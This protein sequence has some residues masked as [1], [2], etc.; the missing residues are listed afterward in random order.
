MRVYV[1]ENAFIDLLLSSTEVYKKECLGILLGYSLTDK[2]VIEHAFSYQTASRQHRAVV[3]NDKSHKRL[4]PVLR[5]LDRIEIIGDFHSHTQFGGTK[6]L[7]IPSEED[8]DGMKPQ[9]IYL[10]IAINKNEKTLLWR[11]NRD[12]T[13]SGSVEDLFYKI[14]AYYITGKKN[15][16][17]ARIH[18]P[19]PPGF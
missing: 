13:V 19:F 5:K 14:S 7:P 3:Y 8:I 11:E 1:S 12:G 10:I 16:R 18:C 6:G 9:N 4:E 15:V 17:R 2:F